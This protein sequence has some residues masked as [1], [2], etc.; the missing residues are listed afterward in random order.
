MVKKVEC[1]VENEATNSLSLS[2]TGAQWLSVEG[3]CCVSAHEIN[4]RGGSD[5][6]RIRVKEAFVHFHLSNSECQPGSL[7]DGSG[8]WGGKLRNMTTLIG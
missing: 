4:C 2:N 1:L 8:I 5:R 3:K 7:I 6:G